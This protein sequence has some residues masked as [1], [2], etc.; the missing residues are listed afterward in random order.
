MSMCDRLLK[1]TGR[2]S[3]ILP[4]GAETEKMIA[5][6][7]AHDFVVS[8][9]TEVYSTPKRGPKRTLL[10]F[11]RRAAAIDE[12]SVNTVVAAE[13]NKLVIQNGGPSTFSEEYRA[14]TRDFYLYF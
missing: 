2:I 6:A 11:L 8:R 14:L 7:A 13:S 1:P 3:L 4:A 12:T 9:R 5:V 10:E